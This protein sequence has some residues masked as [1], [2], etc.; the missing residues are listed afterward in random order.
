MKKA[1]FQDLQ[2]SVKEAVAYQKKNPK[3]EP[4]PTKHK[5]E[6]H[7]KVFVHRETGEIRVI[8][9]RAAEWAQKA[10]MLVY[11]C[12]ANR[13]ITKKG[14]KSI[15]RGQIAKIIEEAAEEAQHEDRT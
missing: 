9:P 15:V 5:W 1:L 2:K 4:Y 13:H 8:Y 11:G 7:L 12:I 10:A 14:I 3:W 6:K